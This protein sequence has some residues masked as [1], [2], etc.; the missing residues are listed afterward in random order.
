MEYK[1]S[2]KTQFHAVSMV[3]IYNFESDF[4][5]F[6]KTEICSQEVAVWKTGVIL[7]SCSVSIWIRTITMG[8]NFLGSC[9][10]MFC[11]AFHLSIGPYWPHFTLWSNFKHG[12]VIRSIMKCGMIL[13]FCS[14]LKFGNVWIISYHTL[15]GIRLLIHSWIEVKPC[16]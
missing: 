10:Y 14:L 4:S 15:L 13:F 16:Q 2:N 6:G 11:I 9:E 3:V 5:C 1:L 7:M 8:F 12:L